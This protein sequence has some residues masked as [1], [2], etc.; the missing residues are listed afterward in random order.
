MSPSECN[1]G[2]VRHADTYPSRPQTAD[3]TRACESWL[4]AGV[5]REDTLQ[6]NER[7]AQLLRMD[8]SHRGSQRGRGSGSVSVSA[9]GGSV[10][11]SVLGGSAVS[12]S[13]CP[14]GNQRFPTVSF[15]GTHTRGPSLSLSL[16]H[17][18]SVSL[19]RLCSL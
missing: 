19:I 1:H 11:R 15:L 6:Q 2:N 3:P 12:R 13:C 5:C 4:R 18:L 8:F 7:R 14:A 9:E 17:S 16:S 10:F